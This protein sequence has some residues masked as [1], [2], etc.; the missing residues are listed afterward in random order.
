MILRNQKSENFESKAILVRRK[1]EGIQVTSFYPK[2]VV[3]L[4]NNEEA[5][6]SL[7]LSCW[8]WIQI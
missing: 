6:S 5:L 2:M 3:R 1:Y 8:L 7:L 4:A